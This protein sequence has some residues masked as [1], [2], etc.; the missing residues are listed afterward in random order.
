M[1]IAFAVGGEVGLSQLSLQQLKDLYLGK[2]N[3]WRELGGPDAKVVLVGREATEA[4]F[5]TLKETY[6]FFQEVRFAKSFRKDHQVVNFLKSPQGGL[7]VIRSKV[8][9]PGSTWGWSTT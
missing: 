7:A 5:S 9:P 4:L 8:S 3:N 6:P 2:I 1:P